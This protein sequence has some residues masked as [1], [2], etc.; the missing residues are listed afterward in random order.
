MYIYIIIILNIILYFGSTPECM[1][2]IVI[3]LDLDFG[4]KIFLFL[5]VKTIMHH[6]DLRGL[7]NIFRVALTNCT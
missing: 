2:K 6:V 7:R 5:M 1:I 4:P 3:I